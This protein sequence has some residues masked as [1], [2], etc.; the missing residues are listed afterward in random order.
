MTPD[1]VVKVLEE[2][3]DE[4]KSNRFPNKYLSEK[5]IALQ[6]AITLLQDY[7][8]LREK[9]KGDELGLKIFI[10][11]SGLPYEQATDFWTSKHCQNSI[12]KVSAELAEETIPSY[13]L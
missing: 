6:S 11:L 3:Y 7:Q 8:K 2:Y 12:K 10:K 1:E 4:I 13:L 9:I 5:Q